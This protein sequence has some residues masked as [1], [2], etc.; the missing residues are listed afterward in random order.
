MRI[1][2]LTPELNTAAAMKSVVPSQ[3]V[4]PWTSDTKVRWNN[5]VWVAI[6]GM[7]IGTGGV[8]NATAVNSVIRSGS[9]VGSPFRIT[10]LD[11]NTFSRTEDTTVLLPQQQLAGLQRYFSLNISDLAKAL[12]VA[13]PTIYAWLR[14]VQPQGQHLARLDQLYRM[15]RSWRSV[16]SSPVGEYLSAP[17]GNNCS[18]L[19][20]L[21]ADQLDEDAVQEALSSIRTARSKK[22]RRESISEVATRRGLPLEDSRNRKRWSDDDEFNL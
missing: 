22:T 10:V 12:R 7:V 4:L 6:L 8:A 21:S 3:S 1:D 9:T 11:E 19:S 17:L 20:Y 16:S 2:E 14:G 15:A 13:R 18:L 5:K